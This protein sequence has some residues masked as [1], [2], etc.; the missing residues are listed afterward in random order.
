MKA[1]QLTLEPNYEIFIKNMGHNRERSN[2]LSPLFVL[3]KSFNL[4]WSYSSEYT[5]FGD[6]D[7]QQ[8]FLMWKI[9]YHYYCD[10]TTDSNS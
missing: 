9:A 3:S 8:Y 6:I 7:Q 2:G 10:I 4:S 5:H 1:K